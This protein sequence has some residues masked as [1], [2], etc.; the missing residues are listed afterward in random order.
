MQIRTRA[1]GFERK[2]A[3]T[4]LRGRNMS[5]NYSD[6]IRKHTLKGRTANIETAK[7]KTTLYFIDT[8]KQP[9]THTS[10]EDKDSEQSTEI[11]H[12]KHHKT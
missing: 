11:S 6:I 3:S 4:M 7:K 12:L 9:L 10:P 8:S 1:G 5:R 2:D